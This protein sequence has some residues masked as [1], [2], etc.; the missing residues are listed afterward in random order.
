MVIE[1]HCLYGINALAGFVMIRGAHTPTMSAL[2]SSL[3]VDAGRLQIHFTF[4]LS[5]AGVGTTP[6]K[7]AVRLQQVIVSDRKQGRISS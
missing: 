7:P 3:A 2:P 4:Q 6:R 1:K 5:M